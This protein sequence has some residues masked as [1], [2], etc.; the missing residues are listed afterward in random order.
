MMSQPLVDRIFDAVRNR[1]RVSGATASSECA[2]S[3]WGRADESLR[4]LDA[5]R[6]AA[7]WGTAA[8][9]QA[10]WR[11][12]GEDT[13]A[14]G[15]LSA[16]LL[17]LAARSPAPLVAA[18]QQS[19]LRL[20]ELAWRSLAEVDIDRSELL[21]ALSVAYRF[22]TPAE[23]RQLAEQTA[24]RA[25]GELPSQQQW[26]GMDAA[27][28]HEEVRRRRTAVE[29]VTVWY[30]DE[31]RQAAEP[32]EFSPAAGAYI[33]GVQRAAALIQVDPVHED[34]HEL[35]LAGVLGSLQWTFRLARAMVGGVTNPNS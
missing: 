3:P 5:L 25:F 21:P 20:Q 16:A 26:A 9:L 2:R 10:R 34:H 31:H 11:G 24:Q 30:W 33:R 23:I 1:L 27:R 29:P 8:V 13:A 12:V 17:D 19:D 18:A 7:G 22:D 15:R 6:S 32:K 35:Y 14:A 4:A 28:R